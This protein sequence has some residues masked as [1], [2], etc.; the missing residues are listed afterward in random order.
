MIGGN[1][2]EN[3]E[4]LSNAQSSHLRGRATNG[5]RQKYEGHP[6]FPRLHT[7]PTEDLA[8]LNLNRL[9]TWLLNGVE[10]RHGTYLANGGLATE[11]DRVDA[12]IRL[13]CWTRRSDNPAQAQMIARHMNWLAIWEHRNHRL[14]PDRQFTQ[15][16]AER[17]L[18]AMVQP[19]AVLPVQELY[20]RPLEFGTSLT[21][22][23]MEILNHN[24]E[25][26]APLD[27]EHVAWAAEALA[28]EGEPALR[29]LFNSRS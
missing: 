18:R 13:W 22:V 27:P 11:R 4:F 17:N 26:G 21:V 24:A 12:A 19:G 16:A 10:T 8:A 23:A 5:E 1:D 20:V 14:Q 9:R 25:H 28:D 7:V 3:E 15:E 2:E 6:D 29:T